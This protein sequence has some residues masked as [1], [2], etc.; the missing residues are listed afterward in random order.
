[1][2]RYTEC[3]YN[4]Q[5]LYALSEEDNFSFNSNLCHSS[6]VQAIIYVVFDNVV[7]TKAIVMCGTRYLNS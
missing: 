7:L 6:V 3:P 4:H 5:C 1:M 2:Y